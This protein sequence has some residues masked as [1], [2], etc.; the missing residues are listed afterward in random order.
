[1]DASAEGVGRE[2]HPVAN[3]KHW[4]AE[5]KESGVAPGGVLIGYATG[6]ARKNKSFGCAFFELFRGGVE[7]N[8]FAIDLL[9]A[10]S[11]GNQLSDLGT[12]I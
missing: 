4:N 8:D 9:F 12:V 1:M 11:P 7:A 6:P 10:D 3:S 5:V 2:L